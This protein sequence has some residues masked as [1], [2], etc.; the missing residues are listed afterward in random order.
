MI[1]ILIILALVIPSLCIGRS[2][3]K[4]K[5]YRNGNIMYEY[6][7]QK[8]QTVR[9]TQYYKS[10]AVKSISHFK[11]GHKHGLWQEF[12]EEGLQTTNAFFNKNKKAGFWTFYNPEG[13]THCSLYYKGNKIF[14]VIQA[15]PVVAVR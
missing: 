9:L 7:K 5:Y 4:Y 6:F 13:D 14:K 15:P 12:T 1:R 2:V 10:G 11:N 3:A 8:N